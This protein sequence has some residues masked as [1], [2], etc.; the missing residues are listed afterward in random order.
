[1][2]PGEGDGRQLQAG[3]AVALFQIAQVFVHAPVKARRVPRALPRRAASGPGPQVRII[4]NEWA[5]A[6]HLT[7][8]GHGP[9]L[10]P[11]GGFQRAKQ[12][13][14]AALQEVDGAGAGQ[15]PGRGDHPSGE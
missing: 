8:P 1:M 10:A 13:S 6:T 7:G 14:G 9:D 15:V 4:V 11:V 12:G 5:N 3:R 2:D